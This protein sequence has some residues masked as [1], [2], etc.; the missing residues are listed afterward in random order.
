[1]HLIQTML[2][3]AVAKADLVYTKAIG[4]IP[5]IHSTWKNRGIDSLKIK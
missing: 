4:S 5:Y 2:V 1:M 3:Y